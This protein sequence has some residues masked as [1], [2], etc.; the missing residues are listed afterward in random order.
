M[1]KLLLPPGDPVCN[2]VA[3]LAAHRV[4]NAA[5]MDF[6]CWRA[7]RAAGVDLDHATNINGP[8]VRK[9][10]S[11]TA[12]GGFEFDPLG[13]TG[14]VTA[15]HGEDAATIVDLVAWSARDPELFGTYCGAGVLG[16][17]S[18]LNP[19]S[20]AGGNP[21]MLLETPLGWLKAG[22]QGVACV[23]DYRA[24]RDAL[25]NAPGPLTAETMDLAESLLRSGI[26]PARKLL[27]PAHWRAAA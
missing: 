25:H 27:L 1:S 15:V 4:F 24:A 26:I 16:L 5:G 2:V 11:F 8:I 18:L 6:D 20:Y 14:F 3:Q 21:C 19:A 22:C 12:W 9:L 17:D 13:E 7:I 23:L 10:V